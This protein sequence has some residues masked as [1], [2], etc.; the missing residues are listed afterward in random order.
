VKNL[1]ILIKDFGDAS[2]KR[3]KWLQEMKMQEAIDLPVK[4]SAPRF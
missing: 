2:E 3:K 1:K 4:K